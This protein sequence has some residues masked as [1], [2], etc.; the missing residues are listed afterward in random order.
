MEKFNDL[1]CGACG[2]KFNDIKMLAKHLDI[3]YAARMLL[4]LINKVVFFNLDKTGHHTAHFITLLAKNNHLIDRYANCI[5]T[6]MDTIERAKIHYELCEKLG[7]DYNK[8]RPFESSDIKEVPDKDKC[9]KI[10]WEALEKEG[11]K[12]LNKVVKTNEI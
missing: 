6:E 1:H 7:L 12:Y 5:A 10:L 2:E 9:L 4:P 8:F 11:N 3:C